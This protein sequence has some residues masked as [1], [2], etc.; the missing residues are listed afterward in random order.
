[1]SD[2]K[3]LR[4]S[5][6]KDVALKAELTHDAQSHACNVLNLSTGGSKIEIAQILERDQAVDL[7]VGGGKAIRGHVA[8]SQTPYYGLRFDEDNEDVAETVMAIAT[9]GVQ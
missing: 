6:R 5:E 7:R 4:Q 2:N 8:W 9:Y 3:N 1:M